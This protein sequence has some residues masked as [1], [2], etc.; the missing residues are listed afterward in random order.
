MLSTYLFLNLPVSS[1]SIDVSQFRPSFLSS[2]ASLDAACRS[3]LGLCGFLGLFLLVVHLLLVCRGLGIQWFRFVCI[4]VAVLVHA[5]RALSSS[6][7]AL[8]VSDLGNDDTLLGL[9]LVESTAS[10]RCRESSSAL[11]LDQL[12]VVRSGSITLNKLL[13]LSIPS[14]LARPL[15]PRDN[16]VVASQ[17][18]SSVPR[19]LYERLSILQ[20]VTEYVCGSMSVLTT[21]AA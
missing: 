15:C 18:E 2:I 16:T 7:V 6:M 1:D 21:K 11:R 17:I 3:A 8:C 19:L 12:F 5:S 20:R 9:P 4:V 10:E 14:Q 13:L